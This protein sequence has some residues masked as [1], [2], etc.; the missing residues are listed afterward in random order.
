MHHARADVRLV[1]LKERLR[2]GR[3]QVALAVR[4]AARWCIVLST[5]LV[6]VW[7]PMEMLVRDFDCTVE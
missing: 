7:L 3:V 6:A 5:S 2:D 1:W 4:L